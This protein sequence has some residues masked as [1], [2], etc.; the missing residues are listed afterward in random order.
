MTITEIYDLYLGKE[1]INPETKALIELAIGEALL[2]PQHIY[3]GYKDKNMESQNGYVT[4]E[5]S[6]ELIGKLFTKIS[7]YE[8][9]IEQIKEIDFESE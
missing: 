8:N 4:Y 1:N 7:K 9:I 5:E 2:N 3:F 6:G